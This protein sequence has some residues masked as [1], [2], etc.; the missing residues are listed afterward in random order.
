MKEIRKLYNRGLW[1]LAV[2]VIALSIPS[3]HATVLIPGGATATA[4]TDFTADVGAQF[5][6]DV[7]YT[8]AGGNQIQV[9]DALGNVTGTGDLVV[10]VYRS[11]LG[12]LDFV[13]QY[14]VTGGVTSDIA[15]L[16]VTNFTGWTTDVGF[17]TG[18]PSANYAALAATL[19]N[20]INRSGNG[21]TVNFNFVPNIMAGGE[22]VVLVVR[23]AEARFA[24]LI[25]SSGVIDNVTAAPVLSYQPTVPEPGSVGVLLGTLF[26]VGLFVARRFRVVQN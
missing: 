17:D 24:A 12:G 19:P 3:A 4:G 11:I 20:N 6:P 2:A 18:A 16:A 8:A 1:V 21:A 14:K 7:K 26:G 13:Y 22:T 9:K 23:V 10:G 5:L 15:T 25:G